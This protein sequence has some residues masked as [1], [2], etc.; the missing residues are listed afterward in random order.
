M[1][2]HLVDGQ[3]KGYLPRSKSVAEPRLGVVLSVR[4]IGKS[5]SPTPCAGASFFDTIGGHPMRRVS[6][7]RL[8]PKI[9]VLVSVSLLGVLAFALSRELT[10]TTR[11]MAARPALRPPRPALSPAEESYIRALWPIH[12][13]VER[14]TVRMSLGQIFYKT[15]NLSRADLKIR[16]DKALVNYRQAESAL[17]ALEP[18]ASL[19]PAHEEYLAAVRLFQQSAVEVLKMFDDGRDDHLLAAYPLSQEGSDKIREVG[20]RFWPGEFP[21]N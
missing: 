4:G 2:G 10:T 1:V 5:E 16:V 3:G 12:G 17:R 18:P 9:L 19:R 8:S 21:P 13:S 20:L 6:G 15:E 7:V 14:S 11:P